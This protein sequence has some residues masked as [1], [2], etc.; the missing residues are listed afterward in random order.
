MSISLGGLASG[1]DV[2]SLID[3]LMS[4]ARLP[5][6]QLTKKKSQVDAATQT[7][8]SL[9]SKLSTL[10]AAA[11]ALTTSTGFASYTAASSDP[12]IVASATGSANV[13]SY[14]IAV[15]ALAKA[16]KSRSDV[17]ASATTALGMSGSIAIAVGSSASVTVNV[18]S[19]DTLADIATKISASGARVSASI[20]NDGTG[21]RLLV[22]GLDTGAANAFTMTES[23]TTL[24]LGTPSNTYQAAQDASLTVDGMAVTSTT[25]Q[26]TGVIPGVKLVLANVTSA[27][28]TVSVSSDPTALHQKIT[29]LVNAYNDFVNS[30]HNASGFGSTKASNSVLA[31]D[32]AVRAALH[33]VGGLF[34]SPVPGTTGLYTTLASVGITGKRD[35]TLS[36]DATKLDAALAADPA[37]VQ[38]LFV[39]DTTTGATGV[40]KSIMDA[41]DA[42]VTGD[43]APLQARLDSLS[44]QSKTLD[45]QATKMQA[46]LDDY[47]AQLQKQFLAMDQAVSKYQAM[48][49]ALTASLGT[50]SSSSGSGS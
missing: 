39:T 50:S 18:A 25:N 24:G 14:A 34:S 4:V 44:K 11:L 10:K 48:S 27:P 49:K 21:S 9:S 31:A 43:T 17:V 41:V 37:T 19:G 33:R 7:I 2:N 45:D 32:S 42:L 1:I 35:G 22:Q 46:R 16:Q 5:V 8:S 15:S 12:A 20:M 3:G 28:A 47:Q 23:G 26:L 13:G 30:A 29:A 40:M 6:D 38:K 36:F